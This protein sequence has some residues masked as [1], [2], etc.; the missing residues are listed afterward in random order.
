VR[1]IV[2]SQAVIDE[3]V[4][5]ARDDRPNEC[6]GL[7]GGSGDRIATA[8]RTRNAF[9]DPMR[10]N[11]H[12]SDLFQVLERELPAAGEELVAMYHSHPVSEARPSQTD[13][14]L[15]DNWP[16]TVWVICSLAEA[17]PVVRAWT[18]TDGAADE[19]ELAVE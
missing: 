17:E 18:I 12:P 14:N 13:I 7:L 11:I 1:T 10:F 6:C 19:V 2:T 4:A 15:S 5:H 16:G 9:E 3:I 8:Y